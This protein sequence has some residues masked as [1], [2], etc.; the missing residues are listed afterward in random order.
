M[1]PFSGGVLKISLTYLIKFQSILTIDV[2]DVTRSWQKN[3]RLAVAR[4]HLLSSVRH[5]ITRPPPGF[6]G[7][8]ILGALS[9]HKDINLREREL[10]MARTELYEDSRGA[11]LKS[12]RAEF[13]TTWNMTNQW[14]NQRHIKTYVAGESI[15]YNPLRLK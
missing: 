14:R 9:F 6:V 12:V 4:I 7:F 13:R 10:W 15:L 11:L 2:R 8:I 5:L 3:R 1:S